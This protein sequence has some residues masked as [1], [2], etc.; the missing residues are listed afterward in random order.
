MPYLLTQPVRTALLL[1][2]LALLL[3]ACASSPDEGFNSNKWS[4]EKLY[5]EARAALDDEYYEN[6]IKY[7]EMLESR[8]PFGP[9][10]EQALLDVSYAYLKDGEADTAIA[11]A[12]RFIKL[13][14][15]HDNVDYAYYLRGLAST[16]KKE[17]LIDRF[18]PENAG[19]E[20][21]RDPT[22]SRQAY[23][24]FSEL[25]KKFPDSKYVPDAMERMGHLRNMLAE[26]EVYVASYYLQRSAY[27]AAAN[28]AKHVIEYFPNTPSSRQ[29]LDI[30]VQAY[31]ALGMDGLAADARRVLQL[32]VPQ[33]EETR[34]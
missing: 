2:M 10:A 25:V 27:V 13:H 24:Y 20:S 33:A 22:S 26:H 19:S 9:Y 14:P 11:S 34:E 21:Q 31:E 18:L 3:G 6:A 7:Y 32:N 23:D 4:V 16:S 1:L 12:D 29:A 28:R 15:R 17:D 5:A 8:F 30:L